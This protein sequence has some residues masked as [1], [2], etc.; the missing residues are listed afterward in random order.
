MAGALLQLVAYGA[1]DVYLTGNPQ[2][3]FFKVVYR[4]HTNFAMESMRQVLNGR[5]DFSNKVTCKLSRNGDLVGPCYVQAV[6]PALQT[7]DGDNEATYHSYTNAVGFRLLR[8]V[9]LRIGGQLI[10]K[11]S[12]TWMYCW[13]SFEVSYVNNPILAAKV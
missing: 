13:K 5:D 12:A 10:D 6:L 9:Q 1:Q 3:T 4:R 8:E 11:Q 2:I 7:T